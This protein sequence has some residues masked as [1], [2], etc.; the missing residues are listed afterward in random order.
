MAAAASYG[1][2]VELCDSARETLER[3]RLINVARCEKRRGEE[4]R[5]EREGERRRR[6]E[7]REERGERN[8]PEEAL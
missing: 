6:E 2:P 8:A 5:E 3:R 4:K 7:K 1:I